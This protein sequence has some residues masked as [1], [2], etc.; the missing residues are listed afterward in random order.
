MGLFGFGKKKEIA[1]DCAPQNAT[2]VMPIK[3]VFKI[4]GRGFVLIGTIESGS[5][6]VDDSVEITSGEVATVIGIECNR[7]TVCDASK[8]ATIGLLISDILP[9]MAKPG[10]VV[11]KC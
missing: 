10:M 11:Y 7:A 4:A 1:Y 2:F 3:E 6:K 8:G 9:H 5:V